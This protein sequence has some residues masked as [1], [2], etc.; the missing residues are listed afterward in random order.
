MQKHFVH[1]NKISGFEVTINNLPIFKY[2][3][4]VAGQLNLLPLSTSSFL[5]ISCKKTQNNKI[6]RNIFQGV[7]FN[8]ERC[9][10]NERALCITVGNERLTSAGNTS[11]VV[12]KSLSPGCS[13]FP[14]LK[15]Y[16]MIN[17]YY[18]Q[19]FYTSEMFQGSNYFQF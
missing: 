3:S 4:L 8:A 15:K 9:S 12:L 10:H 1:K 14:L 18:F 17:V 11:T 16:L 13:M 5:S 6:S 2:P 7:T 19:V